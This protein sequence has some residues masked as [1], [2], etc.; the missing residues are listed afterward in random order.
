MDWRTLIAGW[1][2][3]LQRVLDDGATAR[4][5]A[6][7][8]L[9]L[10]LAALPVLALTYRRRSRHY[11]F[12]GNR[13]A[14][15]GVPGDTA[16]FG[17]W[18]HSMGAKGPTADPGVR[19]PPSSGLPTVPRRLAG[20]MGLA[21]LAGM[22]VWLAGFALA[23]STAA[24]LAAPEWHFQ[25]F[26]V[27][28]HIIALRLFVL[29]YA[30]GFLRGVSHLAMPDAKK[31][32]LVGRILG[33]PGMLVALLIALP[34]AVYDYN[35]LVSDRYEGLG[36]RGKLLAIDY[37]MWVIW[38]G[39]WLLN[40]FIWV[41]LVGFLIKNCWVVRTYRFRAPIEI[42]LHDRQY[43]PFL[44]MSAQGASIVFV[45]SLVTV[46]YIWY[47]G[48]E[49]S[50]YAGLII[51][52]TLLVVGFVP[53]WV[54]LRTKVRQAVQD[55]T[56]AMRQRLLKNLDAAEAEARAAAVHNSDR[57]TM[58]ALEHRLDAAVAI[59][60]ISYLEGRY[61]N[62]G[63]SEARAI[64]VRMLAPAASIGWQVARTQPALV[65]DLQGYLTRFF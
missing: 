5:A 42:V 16:G 51:T 19:E 24:F 28:A 25:P 55:E 45:F 4:T 30:R 50:D 54:M 52:A 3:S 34:F 22:G 59:L 36:G 41:V 20:T 47:T 27:A 12:T 31:S 7:A 39:E 9:G 63:Q 15:P 37:L 40:A 56:L 10:L 64:V 49:L 23:P 46:A 13:S 35:Y 6:V 21:L 18:G 43:Q 48:G 1:A 17:D 11:W 32:T 2:A 60:R 33:W 44:Q 65:G 53:L 61:A 26:Y 29:A 14:R 57:A 58:R 62:L 8:V 38:S